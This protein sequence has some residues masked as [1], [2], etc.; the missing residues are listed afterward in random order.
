[1]NSYYPTREQSQA[2]S[3]N[4]LYF[5]YANIN[6]AYNWGIAPGNLLLFKDPDGAHFYI[7]SLGT[8]YGE[9]PVFEVYTKEQPQTQTEPQQQQQNSEFDSLKEDIAR[10]KEAMKKLNGKLNDRKGGD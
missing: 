6:Q 5:Y 2:P 3:P 7:K 4:Q 8:S 10:L 1:M 9:R